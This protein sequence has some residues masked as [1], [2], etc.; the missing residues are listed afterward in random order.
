MENME[1]IFITVIASAAKQSSVTWRLLALRVR[2]R[3][4]E[5]P[6]RTLSRSSYGNDGGNSIWN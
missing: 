2:C 3:R 6:P 1:I 4:E 5:H